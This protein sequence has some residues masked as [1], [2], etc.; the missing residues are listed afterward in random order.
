MKPETL[1]AKKL[2]T[3]ASA[4]GRYIIEYHIPYIP[5]NPLIPL[6]ISSHLNSGGPKGKPGTPT[7]YMYTQ[8]KSVV[9][10]MRANRIWKGCI[11]SPSISS[12]LAVKFIRDPNICDDAT[13]IMPLFL[14]QNGVNTR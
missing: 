13:S 1:G 3:V 5:K 4:S 6:A 8:E 11:P 9:K 10:L 7:L 14:S 12:S 2:M